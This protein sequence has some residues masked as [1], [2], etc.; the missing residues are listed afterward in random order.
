MC[1]DAAR[2]A[3]RYLGA[4]DEVER[5]LAVVDVSH[6][7]DDRRARLHLGGRVLVVSVR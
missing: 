2:L 4:T 1:C 5:G 6:D 7:G 3:R